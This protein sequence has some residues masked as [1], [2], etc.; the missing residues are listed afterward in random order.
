MEWVEGLVAQGHVTE[1]VQQAAS[2]ILQAAEQLH[3]RP[4][5]L[6]RQIAQ[7][8]TGFHHLLDDV[9][10]L[11]QVVVGFEPFRVDAENM[12]QVEAAVLLAIES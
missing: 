4:S 5:E 7:Q 6:G 11:Q 8:A 2:Q 10:D 12:F 3:G 9:R 1:G